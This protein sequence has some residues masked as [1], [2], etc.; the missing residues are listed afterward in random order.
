MK[1]QAIELYSTSSD[2]GVVRM[3]GSHYLGSV[4]QGDSLFLLHGEAIDMIEDL[5]HNPG[6]DAFYRAFRMA[7]DLE[8]RLEHYISVCRDHDIELNFDIVCSVEDYRE[9]LYDE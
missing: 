9:L 5:K 7:Q 2:K 6:S 8:A 3:P 1:K 4:V